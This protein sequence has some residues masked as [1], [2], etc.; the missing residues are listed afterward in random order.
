LNEAGF[1]AL[2]EWQFPQLPPNALLPCDDGRLWQAEHD[3][4]VPANCPP[5]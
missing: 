2:V 5:A 3:E 4:G 1:Q